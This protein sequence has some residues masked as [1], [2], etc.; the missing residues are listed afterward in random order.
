MPSRMFDCRWGTYTHLC[1]G[2]SRN[3]SGLLCVQT[4]WASASLT[5]AT[6]NLLRHALRDPHAQQFLMLS[7]TGVRGQKT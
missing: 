7:D 1:F 6:R 4:D 2:S 3:S 5:T